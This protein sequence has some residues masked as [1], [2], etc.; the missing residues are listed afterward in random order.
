MT[1]ALM[2]TSARIDDIP[3]LLDTMQRLDLP[4]ILGRHLTRHGLQQ[5]LS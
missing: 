4:A 2:I 5:G 1:T 3:L